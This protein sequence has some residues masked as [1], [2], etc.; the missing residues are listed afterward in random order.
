MSKLYL[1]LYCLNKLI[2]DEYQGFRPSIH[3]LGLDR[4]A[5]SNV[6]IKKATLFKKKSNFFNKGLPYKILTFLSSVLI[7]LSND[8][9][10][11]DKIKGY[12]LPYNYQE[13]HI[14]DDIH[15]PDYLTI[16][17]LPAT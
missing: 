3:G 10:F 9:T 4:M 5:S 15:A 13:K 17:S 11:V 7:A 14:T 8:T 2:I 16:P 6:F 12:C 1:D